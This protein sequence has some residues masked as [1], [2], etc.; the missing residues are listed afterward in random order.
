ML[1]E[2]GKIRSAQFAICVKLILGH[3]KED[4]FKK[5]SGVDFKIPRF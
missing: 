4:T 3:Y 2:R 5:V 1:Q